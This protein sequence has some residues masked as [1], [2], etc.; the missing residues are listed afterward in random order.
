LEKKSVKNDAELGAPQTPLP[1]G[2]WGLFS[3]INIST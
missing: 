2:G 1:S 3:R